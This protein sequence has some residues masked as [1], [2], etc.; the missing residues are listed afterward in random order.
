VPSGPVAAAEGCLEA[1]AFLAAEQRAPKLMEAIDWSF[2]GPSPTSPQ[3]AIPIALEIFLPN[4]PASR[5]VAGGNSC[6]F[7]HDPHSRV[8]ALTR[9]R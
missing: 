6:G 7:S 4:K 1:Q 8:I 2:W 3:R 9:A 5:S